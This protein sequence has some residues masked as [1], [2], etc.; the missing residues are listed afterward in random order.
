MYDQHK[1]SQR[2]QK[3]IRFNKV[4]SLSVSV[5][6]SSPVDRNKSRTS[7]FKKVALTCAHECSF[8]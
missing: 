3:R 8:K 2:L 1:D 6:G 7:V 5:T 4:F